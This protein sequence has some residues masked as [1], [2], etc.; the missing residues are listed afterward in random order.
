MTPGSEPI[1]ELLRKIEALQQK[2]TELGAEIGSLRQ[3]ILGLQAD[4]LLEKRPAL[5]AQSPAILH[6]EPV[7]RIPEIPAATPPPR[8]PRSRPALE[9]FL[10]EN[11][12]NKIGIAILV[13][14]VAIGAKYSI[15]H[16][17]IS[18]LTRIVLGYGAGLALFGIGIRLKEKY[19]AYSAVL[20][21]GAMAILYFITYAAYSFYG[22]LPQ[23]LAFVLLVLFTVFIVVASL[24]YNRQAVALIGLVGAYAVPF[25]LSE[26]RGQV[27]VL[28]A[29]MV[30]INSGILMLSF[31]RSWRLL[32]YTAFA[33]S[34]L[35]YGSWFALRYDPNLHS[36]LAFIFLMLFFVQFYAILVSYQTLRSEPLQIGDVVVL[37]LNAFV[38]YG[39][40]YALLSGSQTGSM[41]LGLFTLGNAVLHFG[42]ATVLRRRQSADKKLFFLVAALVL[43]FVTIAA[44]VQLSGH[45]VTLL[46]TAEAALLFWL[47]RTRKIAVFEG[48]SYPLLVLALC[49]LIQDWGTFYQFSFYGLNTPILP[50]FNIGFLTN[51]LFLAAI[52]GMYQ[53]ARKNPDSPALTAR[54]DLLK[55]VNVA[56]PG[57]LIWVAYVTFRLE[58]SA[59]WDAQNL[60]HSGPDNTYT[61]QPQNRVHNYKTV[62]LAN[63]TL[64]FG[65]ALALLNLGKFRN[66]L[67]GKANLVLLVLGIIG[68][69]TTGLLALSELRDVYLVP[70]TESAARVSGLAVGIRYVSYLFLAAALWAA[71]RYARDYFGDKRYQIG[72]DILLHTNLLWVASS[73]LVNLLAL[74]GSSENYK[75]GLSILW[76]AYAL[77]LVGLGIWKG[78][79]YLRFGGMGLFGIT[80][81]KLFFYDIAYLSTLSKTVV[82]VSLG[83]LLLIISFLYNKY[84]GFIAH[85]K[86]E[87]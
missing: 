15:E 72:Y 74:G 39:L 85:E 13:I 26:G 54:P 6:T 67:L 52:G 36:G 31:K 20:V 42:V 17:L 35:I 21:S 56:L 32:F 38:F 62:W 71:G 18:P 40:G 3:Q 47:G 57:V 81:L 5:G 23:V 28:F 7:P 79:Q 68:F 76:G 8:P 48:L 43:T 46:W 55:L 2:Q 69:L 12:I 65:T 78:K 19:E 37:L 66:P 11:L 45:W 25:L 27:A 84:K 70:D 75:L 44:P 34:W 63:Y 49:S 83:V 50:L 86:E 80:L 82:F 77:L 24:R 58:I 33:L 53:T 9:A 41:Y 4:N 73:E 1:R 22:L 59:Y 51:A 64:L 61:Y 29:Y 14:G 60:I 16:D 87:D 10:G 30:V